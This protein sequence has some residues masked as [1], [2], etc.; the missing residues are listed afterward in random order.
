M[1]KQKILV[2]E[3]DADTQLFL[4]LLLHKKFEVELCKSDVEFD[5]MMLEKKFDLIIMDI[6]IIGKKDGLQLTKQLK[7]SEQFKNI[8]VICLSAH[9]LENDRRN[10]YNAGVDIFLPK[11]VSN[12]KL[13]ETIGRFLSKN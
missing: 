1:D 2:V 4:N 11:P 5:K 12:E 3:D 10:A 6:S 7:G 9:V 13:L 8:P